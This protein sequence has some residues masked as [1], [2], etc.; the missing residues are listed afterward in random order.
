MCLRAYLFFDGL[1]LLLQVLLDETQS[2]RLKD[3]QSW[4]YA[5]H[6]LGTNRMPAKIEGWAL[7]A[8][9]TVIAL[10]GLVAR[11]EPGREATGLGIVQSGLSLGGDSAVG[12]TGFDSG[13]DKET[14]DQLGESRLPSVISPNKD[15]NILPYS[16]F[17]RRP[18]NESPA[19][20]GPYCQ[21]YYCWPGICSRGDVDVVRISDNGTRRDAR[22]CQVVSAKAAASLSLRARYHCSRSSPRAGLPTPLVSTHVRSASSAITSC[23]Y[24]LLV[25]SRKVL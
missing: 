15:Y 13:G 22:S 2:G 6:F 17:W 20:K 3:R 1:Q 7:V 12:S 5:S 18:G 24:L 14:S 25:A 4:P 19:R 16:R 10:V 8:A 9:G 11:W 23:T 21:C